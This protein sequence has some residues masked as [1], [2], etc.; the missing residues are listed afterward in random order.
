MQ[1][2]LVQ[3]FLEPLLGRP[4]DEAFEPRKTHS[5]EAYFCKVGLPDL[6]QDVYE[7]IYIF[8]AL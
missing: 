5:G 8:R 2:T 4:P 7:E 6:R 1:L 3:V